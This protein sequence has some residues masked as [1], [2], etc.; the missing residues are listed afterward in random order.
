MNDSLKR[1]DA[2]CFTNFA[3]QE[4]LMGRLSEEVREE[5]RLHLHDCPQCDACLKLM[6]TETKVLRTA[7]R[8]DFAVGETPELDAET[9]ARYFDDSLS[10]EERDKCDRLLAA[11]PQLLASL[12]ELRHELSIVSGLDP[13]EIDAPDAPEGRILRMPKRQ[14]L[15]RNISELGS[16]ESEAAEA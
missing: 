15:P 5:L 10:D 16:A 2:P 9:L 11:S 14:V 8:D 7:L 13:H 12:I 3:L 4:Y 6:D 1:A